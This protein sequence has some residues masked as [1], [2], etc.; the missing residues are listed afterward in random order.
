MMFLGDF[1]AC[2]VGLFVWWPH[3][4]VTAATTTRLANKY[5][6][7]YICLKNGA[8]LGVNLWLEHKYMA[9][10]TKEY[11]FVFVKVLICVFT[12]A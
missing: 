7:K 4:N 11:V 12:R 6:N 8:F 10:Y 9:S 3:N 2:V 1:R 5:I